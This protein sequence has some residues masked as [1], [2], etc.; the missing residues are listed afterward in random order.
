MITAF[1]VAK[2]GTGKT[3][4]AHQ[5]R[6]YLPKNTAF[7]DLDFNEGLSCLLDIEQPK[8]SVINEKFI[9]EALSKFYDNERHL[10]VDCSGYPTDAVLNALARADNI[11]VPITKSPTTTHTFEKTNEALSDLSKQINFKLTGNVLWNRVNWNS[12]IEKLNA[13]VPKSKY[14]QNLPFFI[15]QDA[16]IASGEKSYKAKTVK[17]IKQL[18]K[19]LNSHIVHNDYLLTEI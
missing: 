12:S 17:P 5:L 14:L 10:I 1:Y 7:L 16:A 15:P 8:P 13:D 4:L 19:L 2:G 11:I 18:V 9:E 3:A 6:F